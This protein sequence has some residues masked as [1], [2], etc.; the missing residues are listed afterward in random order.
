[1]NLMLETSARLLRLLSLLQSRRDWRGAELAGRLGVGLRTVRRDVDRLRDLGYPVDASPG[2]AGGYR[3]GTGGAALPPLLLDD[4]EAVAVAISLHSA[5]TGSV[6]GL[7]ETALRALTKLQAMLPSRLRHKITAFRATTLPLTGSSPA[8]VDPELLTSVAAACRDQRQL[9]LRYQGRSGV[10]TRNVEPHRLVHTTYRWY[11]L[12]WDT[13]RGD[14]RTFRLDR[15]EGPLGL[16]GARFTPRP[17]P[18]DDVAAYVSQSISSA[19]YRYQARILIH[20]P[21]EAVAERSSPAAGRLEA[22]GP[23]TCVLHTGS[24]SLEELAL[25][26]AIKGFDF[27]VLDPPELIPVL[28]ALAGRL[29][30][31]ADAS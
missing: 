4:E 27:Q 16:P 13:G 7:E 11:L 5:T 20:A 9:R 17:P 3:L 15:I 18:S 8:A 29:G 24:D 21:L 2:A 23:H 22:T 30:Q 12:A 25:Y 6:A 19:P 10:T 14:W 31:A 28:R 1:M 26:T